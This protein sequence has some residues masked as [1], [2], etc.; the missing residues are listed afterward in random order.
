VNWLMAHFGM[1]TLF[2]LSV[3]PNPL[4]E[5]AGWTAGATRYPFWKFMAAVTPGKITRGLLLAYVGEK[6]LFG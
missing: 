3:V 6:V 1:P 5:V 4:F 2:T